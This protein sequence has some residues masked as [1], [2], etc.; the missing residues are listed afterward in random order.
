[1]TREKLIELCMTSTL[2]FKHSALERGYQSVKEKNCVFP[3]IGKFG[4]GYVLH[5]PTKHSK[6]SNSY[7]R[8][9]YFVY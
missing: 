8:I 4:S 9:D 2:H 5:I 3:Y 6:C 7:H 1:M